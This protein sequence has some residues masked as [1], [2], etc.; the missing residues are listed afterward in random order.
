MEEKNESK[1][2]LRS[3]TVEEETKFPKAMII[4]KIILSEYG[5][6]MLRYVF[7]LVL[8]VKQ[9]RTLLRLLTRLKEDLSDFTTNSIIILFKYLK[10]LGFV[11]RKT[12]LVKVILDSTYFIAERARYFYRL[13]V[14]EEEEEEE[15]ALVYYQDES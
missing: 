9:Y 4:P 2:V 7:H 14:L 15:G 8:S 1:R 12:A 5:N 3:T 11:Y 10:K 6:N 13:N